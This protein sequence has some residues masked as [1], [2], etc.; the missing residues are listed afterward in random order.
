MAFP[1]KSTKISAG[2]LVYRYR[3]RQ[4]EVL[5]VHPGGPFAHRQDDGHWSIPKGEPESDEALLAAAIREFK[6][7]VGIEAAGPFH[8]L[9]T[10]RQKSGKLV[11]AWAMP[12]GTEPA[13]PPPSMTFRLEWPPSSRQ[14]RDF[15]EVDRAEF[16]PLDRARQKL[17]AAQ[18]AFLDRLEAWLATESS[19]H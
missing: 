2:L 7:E 11:Y 15:P 1:P 8:E 18:V 14:W 13:H 4:C 17:K 19:Q 9:G 6:E 12:G 10:I 5:L 3:H 16:F